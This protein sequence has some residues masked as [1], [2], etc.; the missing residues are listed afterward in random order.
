M[1]EGRA[2]RQDSAALIAEATKRAGLVWIAVA[3][4]DR[5]CPAWHIWH[6]S[7]GP[8]GDVEGASG[9]AYVLTAPGEQPLPGLGQ[10]DQ[11]TVIVPS[12]ESGGALVSWTARV[13]RVEPA[14]REWDAV[15]V[16]LAAGRLNVRL[17]PGET[18]PAARWARE[19]AVYRLA[20]A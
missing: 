4:Q 7:P 2:A 9:A 5:P 11:V 20:P 6:A 1:S 10:A 19:A 3:G 8:A 17:A 12:K 13:T 14:S 15:I 18:S 16:A